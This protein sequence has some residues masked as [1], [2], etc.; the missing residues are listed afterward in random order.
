MTN[1]EIACAARHVAKKAVIAE[2]RRRGGRER[3][4]SASELYRMAD[5]YL[6]EH[7]EAVMWGTLRYVWPKRPTADID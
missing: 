5:Q 7:R 1:M 3:D 4:H 2:L 6:R